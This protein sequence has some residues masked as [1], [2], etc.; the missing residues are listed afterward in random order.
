M[1]VLLAVAVPQTFASPVLHGSQPGRMLSKADTGTRAPVIGEGPLERVV[2]LDHGNVLE[3]FTGQLLGT[4]PAGEPAEVAAAPYAIQRYGATTVAHAKTISL[5]FDDGPD[6]EITPHLLDVLSRNHVPATFFLVGR[7]IAR[8]PQIVERMSRE[9][10]AV[11][12]HTMTHPDIA[13]EPDW[14]EQWELV[15]TERMIRHLTG[16]DA[17]IWRM[18]YTAPD[19]QIMQ[20]TIDG[21]LRAQRLGFTHASYT[22][23]TLDWQHDAVEGG[24]SEDIPLPDLTTGKDLTVLLHDAGG[25]NRM[26]SVAYVQ[27]LVDAAKA[28]GYTFT[29]MPQADPP[30]AAATAVAAPN[31]WDTAA[32]E[33][34][35]FQFAWPS[36]VMKTLFALAVAGLVL[37][38]LLNCALVLTRRRRTRAKHWPSPGELGVDTSVVLAAYNEEAVIERT[39]RALMSSDYPVREFIVIDDGSHD[40]TADIV[41]SLSLEDPR[42][43]LLRQP[44]SG[45]ATALNSGLAH[46]TSDVLVTLDADTLVDAHTVTNLVRHFAVDQTG[47]LGAVAGVVRVG[48]R[49]RNLLTR[50]QALEYVTQIGLE[51]GAQDA[52]G[53]IS[54]VPGACAAWRREAIIEA[55]GYSSVTLAEDCDL[56]LTLHRRHWLIT[57]DDEAMAYTEAPETVDDLLKQRTRWT[58]G[59]LQA[60]YKNR[61]MI[62][63]PRYGW[64]GCFVLP[65][66]LISLAIPLLFLPFVLTMALFTLQNDGPL[67]LVGYFAVFLLVQMAFAAIAVFVMGERQREHLL[68]VPIYRVVYEPL[69]AY[70]LYTSVALV[71]TGVRLGWNKL[72]RTGSMDHVDHADHADTAAATSGDGAASVLLDTPSGSTRIPVGAAATSTTSTTS[73]MEV[74]R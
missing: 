55:G 14:R 49:R 57:Q 67:M 69:R 27:R 54:I 72:D 17:A 51:R 61:D 29:T 20:S 34:A 70:L 42:V 23:D 2:R 43:V 32:Y 39:L 37:V 52:L 56:A 15:T 3:P 30:I 19:E 22:Y 28:Q 26:R 16:R 44:N 73:S 48:N 5:T 46:A 31:L 53:A 64:L 60:I 45:K 1:L 71:L 38:G 13:N 24:R 58:F 25:P 4:V 68:M 66:Y 50:W 40:R 65:N 36:Y 35:E 6:A 9:G 7:N 11:G 41:E 12:V 74:T 63:R 21:L 8:S 18:P 33:L 47:R 62:L 59:T 10:H